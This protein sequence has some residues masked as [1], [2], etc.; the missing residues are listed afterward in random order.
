MLLPLLLQ[1]SGVALAGAPLPY[2]RCYL[3]NLTGTG[4]GRVLQLHGQVACEPC[5]HL[6][7]LPDCGARCRALNYT[8]AGVEAGH[9]CICGH[10]IKDPQLVA[11]D[12]ECELPC[13]GIPPTGGQPAAFCGGRYRLWAANVTDI[14]PAPPPPPPPPPDFLE[15]RDIRDGIMVLEEEY[16]DQCYCVFN[17]RRGP[18]E[19][20]TWTCVITADQFHEGGAGEHI[21]ALVSETSGATWEQHR[22]V[23]PDNMTPTSLPNAY[24]TIALAPNGGADGKGRVYAIYNMNL[25]NVTCERPH[26]T[27][28]CQTSRNDELGSFVMKYSDDGGRSWSAERLHVPYPNTAIDRENTWGGAVQIMWNVDLVKTMLDGK[29]AIVGFTKIGTYV[30][31]APQELF[32]LTSPNLLSE[33]NASKVTWGLVPSGDHGVPTYGR[34]YIVLNSA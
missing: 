2:G 29:T 24:A 21:E 19:H 32:Y 34:T 6:T 30:Q 28:P 23:E 8:M 13:V 16:L 22:T 5:E 1:S 18:P 26:A 3:D 15:S 11:P 27:K 20:G 33:V 17:P 31:N 25:R 14:P 4:G 7:G 10:F 9:E 12:D